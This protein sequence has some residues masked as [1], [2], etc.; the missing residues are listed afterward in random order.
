MTRSTSVTVCT[1]ATQSAAPEHLV[2]SDCIP[3]GGCKPRVE[4]ATQKETAIN[5]G[6]CAL[7]SKPSATL[8]STR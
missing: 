8:A 2:G 4:D 6:R 7:H 5:P 1:P 3:S